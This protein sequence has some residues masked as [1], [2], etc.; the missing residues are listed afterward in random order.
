MKNIDLNKEWSFSSCGVKKSIDV[1]F[2]HLPVGRSVCE[3][4]FSYDGHAERVFLKFDG[5]TYL[6]NVTFNGKP[7]GKMLPYCE[8]SFDVTNVIDKENL[9][10]VELED[11]NAA[12]G[13]TEGWEN[14]GGIIRDVSLMLLPENHITDVF[15][16]STLTDGFTSAEI[17][18]DVEC[19]QNRGE[20]EISLF[21]GEE[22][23]LCYTQRA[24]ET[25]TQTLKKIKLWSPDEPHLYRLWNILV[26][27]YHF[28]L[29]IH[30]ES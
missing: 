3:K 12:F 26:H 5:I 25:K 15:F 19:A 21:D 22:K 28:L 17:N 14:F 16:K 20:I 2:S 13:P 30:L 1:P 11:I 27:Q 18:V 29:D 9:I 23:I 4:S 7:L 10:S 6:A 8:Y 24:G